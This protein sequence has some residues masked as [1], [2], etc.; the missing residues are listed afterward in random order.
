MTLP[1]SKAI[2]IGRLLISRII[3]HLGK[4]QNWSYLTHGNMKEFSD[5]LWFYKPRQPQSVPRYILSGINSD[6]A[7]MIPCD[8]DKDR[9]Q[10]ELG[11]HLKRPRLVSHIFR[12]SI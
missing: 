8:T 3:C 7:T 1:A 6:C 2:S 11:S 9:C 10:K 12:S 4:G 5:S